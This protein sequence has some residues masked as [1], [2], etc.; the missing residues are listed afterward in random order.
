MNNSFDHFYLPWGELQ[1]GDDDGGSPWLRGPNQELLLYIP[2]EY[3]PYVQHPP[4]ILRIGAGRFTI[5][6]TGA[7]HGEDWT[8]IY[9][10]PK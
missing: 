2:K 10:G 9:V 8:K 1:S 7:A 3:R 5:D 6:W 4:A